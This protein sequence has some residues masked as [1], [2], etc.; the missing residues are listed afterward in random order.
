MRNVST[1]NRQVDKMAAFQRVEH[2]ENDDDNLWSDSY[3]TQRTKLNEK[4]EQEGDTNSSEEEPE[5]TTAPLLKVGNKN[6]PKKKAGRKSQWSD[7]C[8]DDLVDIICEEQIYQNKLIFTNVKTARN[9][10][11]YRKILAEM[12]KR[13]QQRG[14]KSLLM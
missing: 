10:G 2:Y 1:T 6:R 11:Y 7:A 3:F 12:K 9:T 5:P 8:T 4:C 13:G 14:K